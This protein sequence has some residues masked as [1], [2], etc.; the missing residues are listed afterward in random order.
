VFCSVGPPLAVTQR[1]KLK[2]GEATGY[3]RKLMCP[4]AVR[5]RPTA[6]L[7]HH[8]INTNRGQNPTIFGENSTLFESR[9]LHHR[10]GVV[11]DISVAYP[12]RWTSRKL[13]GRI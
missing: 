3:S 13:E 8:R 11:P 7:L 12:R 6:Q 5:S 2:L 9:R 1:Q 10:D 4:L